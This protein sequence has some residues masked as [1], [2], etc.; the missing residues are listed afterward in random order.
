MEVGA[1]WVV[2]DAV[3][4][5]AAVVGTADVGD[6]V[7]GALA[8]VFDEGDGPGAG[9]VSDGLEGPDGEV[10]AGC[11]DVVPVVGSSVGA[12][13]DAVGESASP[14]DALAPAPLVA[15]DPVRAP[16]RRDAGA[17]VAPAA[18]PVGSVSAPSMD[19]FA[20]DGSAVVT[21]T[22]ISSIV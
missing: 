3:V 2:A 1:G 4:A 6:V 12:A 13:G 11:G 17:G 9:W 18:T 5:G 20:D 7:V 21:T 10:L 19:P 16:G 14:S 15:P 8:G 22:T